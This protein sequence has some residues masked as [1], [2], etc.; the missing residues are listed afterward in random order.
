MDNVSKFD[1]NKKISI[2]WY[3]ITGILLGY[4]VFLILKIN[5]Y[6]DYTSRY[7]I[8]WIDNIEVYNSNYLIDNDLNTTWG[9]DAKF[10]QGSLVI[11]K[12]KK[13]RSFGEIGI[14]NVADEPTVPMSI[15]VFS[16]G[17][18]YSKCE[19]EVREEGN[20][21]FYSIPG[22]A[23]GEYIVLVYEGSDN[24]H[25]PITEVMINE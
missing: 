16:D 25:W 12:L 21:T 4:F 19:T 10:P 11:I 18:N 23:V 6:F 9:L 7:Q 8:E 1:H 3:V 15:Y 2:K 17:E 22:K 5:G 20:K 13:Q 14:I 24:G